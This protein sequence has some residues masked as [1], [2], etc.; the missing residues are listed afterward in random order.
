M[1][2]MSDLICKKATKITTHLSSISH[3]FDAKVFVP[4]DCKLKVR[5]KA[6]SFVIVDFFF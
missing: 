2:H 5:E 4:R 6:C 3:S 1:S